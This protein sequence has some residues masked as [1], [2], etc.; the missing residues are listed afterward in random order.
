[1][2]SSHSGHKELL[3][4]ERTISLLNDNDDDD[5]NKHDSRMHLVRV[6]GKNLKNIF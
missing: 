1:M 4:I 2:F 5:I 6:K 3:T